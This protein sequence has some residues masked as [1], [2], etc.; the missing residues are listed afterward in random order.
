LVVLVD[1]KRLFVKP[2]PLHRFVDTMGGLFWLAIQWIGSQY[3]GDARRTWAG[4]PAS[5]EVVYRF[6]EFDGIGPEIAN[7]AVNLLV[8]YFKI[9]LADHYSIAIS[10]DVHVRRV[11]GRLGLCPP[12]STTDQL[13]YKA[14][15]LHPTFPGIIDNPCW[16]IGRSWCRPRTPLCNECYMRDLCPTANGMMPTARSVL[17][18]R[19]EESQSRVLGD[20]PE[21]KAMSHR[22][23]WNDWAR[24]HPPDWL[25]AHKKVRARCEVAI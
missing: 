12:D 10:A 9:P 20:V 6:L 11:F 8:R 24:R 21:F 16:E 18:I 19:H 1:V 13:I 15:A 3:S 5:A 23:L 2:T 22:E 25:R 14:Q 4:E 17:G 7:M